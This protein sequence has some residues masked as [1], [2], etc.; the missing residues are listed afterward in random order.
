MDKEVL[1]LEQKSEQLFTKLVLVIDSRKT[2]ELAE[3]LIQLALQLYAREKNYKDL[4]EL[5]FQDYF[6]TT[7]LVLAM[8]ESISDQMR[9]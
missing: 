6:E 5:T 8:L 7:E 4:E 9:H 2:P 3:L 1:T